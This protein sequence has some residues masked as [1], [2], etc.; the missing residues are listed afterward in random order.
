M[1]PVNEAVSE[2]CILVH[3]KVPFRGCVKKARLPPWIEN[4]SATKLV[5]EGRELL[6]TTERFQTQLVQQPAGVAQPQPEAG[7]IRA[8]K[9]AAERLSCCCSAASR[10]SKK[11]PWK[12]FVC[13]SS[14]NPEHKPWQMCT[15]EDRQVSQWQ[16]DIVLCTA[17]CWLP[18]L[19]ASLPKAFC[20]WQVFKT[21]SSNVIWDTL[22]FFKLEDLC[23]QAVSPHM[24]TK[25]RLK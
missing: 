12:P 18:T 19:V 20:T 13:C 14:D 3:N 17:L 1:L 8:A 23:Y 2:D 11:C 10:D 21:N 25:T 16:G 9:P 6:S 22:C 24:Q 5:W 4:E 7:R 15:A